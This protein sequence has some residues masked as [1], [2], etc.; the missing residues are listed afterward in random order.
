MIRSHPMNLSTVIFT[1]ESTWNTLNFLASTENI[2]FVDQN[3]YKKNRK[4]QNGES[5][6]TKMIKRCENL[7]FMFDRF[8]PIF[9]EFKIQLNEPKLNSKVYM[10]RIDSFCVIN[11][12]EPQKYFETVE[13]LL[14]SRF[15]ALDEQVNN[16]HIIK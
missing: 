1:E 9:E 6:S 3:S 15:R 10:K 5:H 12:I 7:L 13:T 2:M 8:L 16:L 14:F 11:A 4:T